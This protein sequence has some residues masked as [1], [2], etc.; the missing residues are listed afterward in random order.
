MIKS[1]LL[2]VSPRFEEFGKK[3]ESFLTST[4]PEQISAGNIH[5]ISMGRN[6]DA[7]PGLRGGFRVAGTHSTMGSAILFEA[8]KRMIMDKH[9]VGDEAKRKVIVTRATDAVLAMAAEKVRSLLEAN[10]NM[11]KREAQSRVADSIASVGFFDHKTGQ[12]VIHRTTDSFSPGRVKDSVLSGLQTPYWDIAQIPKVFN[13][14]FLRLYASNLVSEVGIPNPW[15]NLVQVYTQTFEG[16]ARLANVAKG[17]GDFNTTTG[18]KNR[19]ST[20]ISE[21]VNLVIDYEAPTPNDQKI[22]GMPGNWLSNSVIGD[23]DAYAN[24]MLEQLCNLLYYFGDSASG[25]DGLTQIANRDSTYTLYPANQ[26][27]AEYLWQ[28]DGAGT[29]TGPVNTT[30][31][32]D[33]LL[34]L[35]HMIAE[36]VQALNFLPVTVDI[37]VSPIVYKVLRYSMLSKTF[38]QK[39]PLSIIKTAF[40]AEGKIRGTMATGSFGEVFSA[41]TLTPDPALMPNTPFNPTA[42]DLTFI[43]FKSF[44]SAMED[45]SLTD[46]VMA[47]VAISKMILPS[48]PGFRDGVVRTMLKRLGSLIAP[49]EGT[50]HV[51]SGMGI[52]SRYTPPS[53]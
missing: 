48:A 50:V 23:R 41:Y 8:P 20:I 1:S 18:V 40:E 27:P 14:P 19:T 32:A 25:Y 36:K 9:I 26:P 39:N 43:T 4:Y 33:L 42:E 46:L 47:P 6:Q 31:G 3:A 53:T 10:P 16:Y 49:V 30:V 44:Q 28:N 21:L 24:L 38:N 52:N 51:I 17:N 11:S 37:N 22:G 29:G 7:A 34:V 15:A 13:Q 2:E 5:S 45:G 12:F 35:N